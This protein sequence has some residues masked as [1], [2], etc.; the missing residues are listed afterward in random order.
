MAIRDPKPVERYRVG[1]ELLGPVDGQKVLDAGCGFAVLEKYIPAIGVD[2]NEPNLKKAKQGDEAL[3][4]AN[5]AQIPFADQFFDAAI[6]LETLEHV[7]DEEAVLS[8]IQRTLKKGG[9]LVLSVPN[10]HL[11]YNL[12][13]LEHWLVPLFSKR[14]SHRHYKKQKLSRML[15]EKKFKIDRCLERGMLIAACM[16]WIYAPFDLADYYFFGRLLG[17]LG[18]GMRKIFDRFVDWEFGIKTP[19]GGSLFIVAHK[20]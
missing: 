20:E 12:I 18:R 15:E 5:L 14:S 4:R 10:H 6:M 3:V 17:P 8:E 19:F 16:R 11:L 9:K 2:C 13:D 1:L 7:G